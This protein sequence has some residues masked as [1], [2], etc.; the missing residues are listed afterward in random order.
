MEKLKK[1]FKTNY[2]KY[3]SRQATFKKRIEELQRS[4]EEEA[5][6][7]GTLFLEQ[8]ED[9]GRQIKERI[10]TVKNNEEKIAL[11]AKLRHFKKLYKRLHDLT[12]SNLRHWTEAIVIAAIVIFILRNFVFG[13]YHVPSGSAEVNLLVGD[14]VWGNNMAYSFWSKPKHGDLVMFTDPN[15]EYDKD[16]KIKYFWQKYIGVAIPFLGFGQGADN[17]VKRVIACPGDT[18]EGRLEDGRSAIYLNGK[19]LYE[20]YVNI[21]PL[22]ALEKTTGFVDIEK[23]WFLKIPRFLKLQRKIVHYSFDTEKDFSEQPFYKMHSDEVVLRP[24]TVFPWLKMPNTPTKNEL[25]EIVDVFPPQL[26]PEG[27]YWV[28]GDSRK[29]SSDSRFWGSLDGSLIYGR[30]SFILYSID[31]EE[32]FWIFEFLKQP[33]SFWNRSI[34]WDR[35]LKSLK[36]GPATT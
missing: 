23:I 19:K 33:F 11:R 12:K 27:K 29:N 18:I 8:I 34:R 21:Y 6:K 10:D 32:P 17:I 24:G 35:F 2:G 36:G 5:Y 20:P 13:L 26:L 15:F 14:R 7:E 31:G 22:L 1:K 4:G 3:I 25:G 28:M 9:L 30:A 16:S